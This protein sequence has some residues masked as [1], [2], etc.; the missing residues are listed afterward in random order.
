MNPWSYDVFFLWLRMSPPADD[1]VA[2]ATIDKETAISHGRRGA[3]TATGGVYR[4]CLL[5]L[6]SSFLPPDW[7]PASSMR[8]H[9]CPW[10]LTPVAILMHL[11]PLPST[12]R[13]FAEAR[14]LVVAAGPRLALCGSSFQGFIKA[15]MLQGKSLL[16]AFTRCLQLRLLAMPAE[17][18]LIAGWNVFAVDGSLFDAP[19]TTSNRRSLGLGGTRG[20]N[21]QGNRIMY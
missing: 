5:D 20:A 1:R 11:S 15:L 13:R 19:R 18:L 9:S 16:K 4:H 14:R 17:A 6:L 7:K 12:I 21:P 10:S 8:G 3:R 2:A